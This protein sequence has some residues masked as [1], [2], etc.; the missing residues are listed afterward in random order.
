RTERVLV[1]SMTKTT[2]AKAPPRHVALPDWIVRTDVPVPTNDSFRSQ[3]MSTRIH[4]FLMS[5]IDGQRTISDM[6]ELMESQRLMPKDEAEAT[7]RTFLIRMFEEAGSY[8]AL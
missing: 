4:A 1:M 5:M 3:A 8:R 2:D 7:L 6:A